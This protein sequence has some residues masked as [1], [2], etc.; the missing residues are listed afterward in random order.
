MKIYYAHHMYKYNT[1]IEK[2]EIEL[3]QKYLSEYEIINPNGSINPQ[4]SEHEIMNDCF[5]IIDNSSALVFSSMD[6]VVGK[7]VHD[8]V[9]H[10]IETKKDIYYISDNKLVKIDS[11]KWNVINESHR[12]YATIK[13][14]EKKVGK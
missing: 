9:N 4:K 1:L 11:I 8:E 2:Y 14:N 6:G 5:N 3:I 12:I 7:G 10:A 13:F